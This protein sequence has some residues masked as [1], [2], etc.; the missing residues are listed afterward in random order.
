MFSYIGVMRKFKEI[1]TITDK[2]LDPYFITKDE[3]C[4]TVKEKVNPS[5]SHFRTQGK[6][7]VYEK[8]LYYFPSFESAVEKISRMKMREKD[9]DS[10]EGYINEFKSINNNLKM[11]LKEL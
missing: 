10:L 9:Y 4:F 6:G 5:K 1:Q 7:K 3:N 2:S 8:S 11:F